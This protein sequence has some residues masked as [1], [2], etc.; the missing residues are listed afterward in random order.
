MK[1]SVKFMVI[2]RHKDKYSISE[3][4]RFFSV[5]RSGYYGYVL[6]MDAPAKDLMLAKRIQECQNKCG[7]TYG[8]RRVHIWLERQ[9]IHHNPK[10]MLRVMRKYNLF[11]VV[12]RRKYRNYGQQLHKYRNLLNRNFHAD[13][14]NEKWVTDISYI[15]TSQGTLYLSIIR[16]LYDNSIVSYKTGTEQN[17]NLVLSTIRSANNKEKVTAETQ[18]HSD[19]G[20]QYTSQ[21]YF[22]LTQSYGITPSMSRRGNPYDNA[23]A[24]NFFSILKTECI[25][26]VRLKTYEE[27]RLLISEYI[28]FYNNERIQLKTKLTPLEKRCQYVAKN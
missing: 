22:K 20:F 12:R 17:I 7:K 19:Q 11:S 5:S 21:G 26:R 16:D 1:A 15:K 25:N 8:Y 4:C 13:K 6:R 2:Y 23:L 24:E 9:D 27:A 18:L 10:T 3:M 28:H 14:P